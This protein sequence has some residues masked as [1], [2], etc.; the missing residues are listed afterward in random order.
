MST[1]AYHGVAGFTS[2]L[3]ISRRSVGCANEPKPPITIRVVRPR[4]SMRV[5]PA[6]SYVCSSIFESLAQ[7]YPSSGVPPKVVWGRGR[8]RASVG[9]SATSVYSLTIAQSSH[10]G[11]AAPS[12]GRTR[13]L[14]QECALPVRRRPALT[15]TSAPQSHRQVHNPS[16]SYCFV[17]NWPKTSP[18]FRAGEPGRDRHTRRC[19]RQPQS[20]TSPPSTFISAAVTWRPHRHRQTHTSA[21]RY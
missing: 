4:Q 13:Q 7:A 9:H 2:R 19:S 12:A 5:L 6:K 10:A 8:D 17:V 14:P 21:P 1:G 15:A 18:L 3:R 20:R 11:Y 16:P